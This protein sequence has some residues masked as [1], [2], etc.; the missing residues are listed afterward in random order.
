MMCL[1][2]KLADNDILSYRNA[3]WLNK[4]DKVYYFD[5]EQLTFPLYEISDSI[6]TYDQTIATNANKNGLRTSF[7]QKS[8]NYI[9][10]LDDD[11]IV[12]SDTTETDGLEEKETDQ[13]CY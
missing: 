10:T 11:G 13:S 12:V 5:L 1:L 8:H 4:K 2:N 7:L 3:Y 9:F 6:Y